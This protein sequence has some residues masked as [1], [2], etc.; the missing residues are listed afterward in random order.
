MVCISPSPSQKPGTCAGSCSLV[1]R[2]AAGRRRRIR[3]LP[4][5]PD[6]RNALQLERAAVELRRVPP[7]RL[8]VEVRRRRTRRRPAAA[9]GRQACAGSASVSRA[10]GRRPSSANRH[11]LLASPSTVAEPVADHELEPR[12]DE[13]VH[14]RRRHER[15]ARQQ[16][17]ADA[18]RARL[19]QA[20]LGLRERPLERDVAAEARAGRAHARG[21]SGRCRC[22]RES[23]S[24]GG[25]PRT[26]APASRRRRARRSCRAGCDGGARS[27]R[28][29]ARRGR[30]ASRPCPTLAPD[31][32]VWRPR[33]R[34]AR[35]VSCD[36]PWH[37]RGG[38]PEPRR[39]AASDA[40]KRKRRLNSS[41]LRASSASTVFVPEIAVSMIV[42]RFD[43][44]PSRPPTAAEIVSLAWIGQRKADR[45][46]APPRIAREQLGPDDHR[47]D[48]EHPPRVE[49]RALGRADPPCRRSP[50]RRDPSR[51]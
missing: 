9:S 24:S 13:R 4:S 15:V 21:R 22:R 38:R 2:R 3:S 6:R 48:A 47:A 36:T 8:G 32:C 34:S 12:R 45:E 7:V 18:A 19:L 43:V 14:R 11:V 30:A 31:R 5:V 23:A 16:L 49:R 25:A 42:V 35:A 37:R 1:G 50:A 27:A 26:A 46:L 28:R 40:P 20:R 10:M 33:R 17:A 51:R 41:V 44:S 39:S 29:S